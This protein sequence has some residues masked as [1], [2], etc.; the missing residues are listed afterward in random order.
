MELAQQLAVLGAAT[1]LAAGAA[2]G[3]AWVFLRGAFRL[4]QPAAARL[5]VQKKN[6]GNARIHARWELANGTRAAMRGFGRS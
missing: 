3:M 1:V 4:M 6:L 5:Q 2:F